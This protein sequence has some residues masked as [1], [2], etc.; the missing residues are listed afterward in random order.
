MLGAANRLL[1]ADYPG[2]ASSFIER[3]LQGAP[4]LF[5]QGAA[6]DIDPLIDVQSRFEPA[7]SQGKA[8]GAEV[9]RVVRGNMEIAQGDPLL[10]W[11]T[12]DV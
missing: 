1:T 11:K 5:L 3:E 10:G 7:E 9:V 12:E 4:A 6:G 8:L 2:Y